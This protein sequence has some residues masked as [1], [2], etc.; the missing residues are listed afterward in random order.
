MKIIDKNKRDEWGSLNLKNKE[1]FD[2]YIDDVKKNNSSCYMI[3]IARDGES[4]ARSIIFYDNAIDATMVYGSYQDWG[5]AKDFLTVALYEPNGKVH[6][7]NLKRPS[8]LE[9]NFIRQNYIDISQIIFE[10][11]DSTENEV[12]ENFVLKIAKIFSKDNLRFDQK[13]FFI[14]TGIQG[15]EG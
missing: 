9:S 13:R 1:I 3:T 14:D 10:I 7:K 11:K 8:G 5:F 15:I 4:P 2:K 6:K 12:Y